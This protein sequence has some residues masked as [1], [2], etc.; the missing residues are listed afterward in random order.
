MRAA[1][2]DATAEIF[3]IAAVI[4]VVALVAVLLIKER[5]LRRT[6]DIQPAARSAEAAQGPAG[7]GHEVRREDQ[8]SESRQES[9]TAELTSA[10][11]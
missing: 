9:P 1:Y 2:G 8:R 5:P 6:V 4:A 11:K 7:S 10:G 3:L